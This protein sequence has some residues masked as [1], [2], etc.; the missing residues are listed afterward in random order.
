MQTYSKLQ[1]KETILILSQLGR[2][3]S[4]P[5]KSKIFKA[6]R[7]KYVSFIMNTS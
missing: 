5:T 3:K 2:Y 1:A 6:L 7:F 4:N